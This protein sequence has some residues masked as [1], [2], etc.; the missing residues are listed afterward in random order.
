MPFGAKYGTLRK[1][2]LG[3]IKSRNQVLTFGLAILGLIFSATVAFASNDKRS[4]SAVLVSFCILLPMVALLVL[5]LWEA[6]YLRMVR[7]STYL[8]RLENKIN[9]MMTLSPA[10]QR[11]VSWETNLRHKKGR[12]VGDVLI[13]MHYV[14]AAFLLLSWLCF[15]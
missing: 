8:V 9:N 13:D 2:L 5:A 7:A 15:Q 3:T 12:V 6:E 10:D 4:Q 14:I 11:I 1:E